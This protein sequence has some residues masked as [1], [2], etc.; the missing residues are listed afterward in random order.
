MEGIR[1]EDRRMAKKNVTGGSFVYPKSDLVAEIADS[2]MRYM[3][4]TRTQRPNVGFLRRGRHPNGFGDSRITRSRPFRQP[5]TEAVASGTYVNPHQIALLYWYPANKTT[6]FPVGA[7][8]HGIAF[9]GTDMWV[10][11][12]DSNIT[13]LQSSTGKV[14][15]TFAV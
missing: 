6:S 1:D 9:D 4:Q 10:A 14:L 12:F 7:E 2:K 13:E 3:Y 11:N 5:S 15:G 8:P